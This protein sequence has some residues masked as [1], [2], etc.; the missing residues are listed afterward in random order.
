M[1]YENIIV[2]TDQGIATIRFNALSLPPSG[3]PQ[4]DATSSASV[5]TP[6]ASRAAAASEREREPQRDDIVR[7]LVILFVDVAQAHV[8]AVGQVPAH[9]V[10]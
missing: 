6:S 8:Q 10:E 5:T 2:E 4:P 9:L 1:T 7:L 3:N